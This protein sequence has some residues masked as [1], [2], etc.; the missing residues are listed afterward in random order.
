MRTIELLDAAE[1]EMADAIGWYEEQEPGLGTAIRETF[2]KTI[3][4]IQ[5]NPLAYPIVHGSK[6]RRALTTRFPYAI[7][8]LVEPDSMLVVA[9]FHTSRNPMIWRGRVD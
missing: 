1:F 7:V 6:V 9:V 8:F 2:E 4:T 5:A 3:A